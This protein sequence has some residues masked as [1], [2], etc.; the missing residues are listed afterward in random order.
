MDEAPSSGPPTFRFLRSHGGWRQAG[1]RPISLGGF[2]GRSHPHRI[3]PSVGQYGRSS[4]LKQFQQQSTEVPISFPEFL[5]HSA[6][7]CP[8]SG[9]VGEARRGP[10]NIATASPKRP[11]VAGTMSGSAPRAAG[12]STR[13]SGA[14]RSPASGEQANP[15]ASH[16]RVA[17]DACYP[18]LASRTR[19][20]SGS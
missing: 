11:P 8:G 5:A 12:R 1:P 4:A 10:Q 9:K 15:V 3:R 17:L 13:I 14:A 2:Q 20:V 16:G 19:P 18:T 7:R 6:R